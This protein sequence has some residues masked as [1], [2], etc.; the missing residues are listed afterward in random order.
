MAAPFVDTARITVK[1]GSG[2]NGAVAF[3][4]EKY[5]A[6]GGPDG[7]DGGNG[8][9]IVLRVDDNY[10]GWG[11]IDEQ[12]NY[13]YLSVK[14]YTEASIMLIDY[15]NGALDA[16]IGLSFSDTRTVMNEG[17]KHSRAKVVSSGNYTVI[18]LPTYVEAFEDPRVR[19]AIFCAIDTD[20]TAMAAYGELGI[21]M[22]AYVSD[23]FPR[24]VRYEMKEGELAGRTFYGQ[25]EEIHTIRINGTD[26]S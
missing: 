16:C 6:A 19:E 13:D 9:S 20:A 17:R 21:A 15:E 4:R 25:T 7:G 1:A 5:V 10:W 3:H 2:G 18:C 8:G 24:V 22:D 23:S 14:F 11:I 12:P 26:S